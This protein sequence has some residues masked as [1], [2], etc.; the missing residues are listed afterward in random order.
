MASYAV[1]D[2]KRNQNRIGP[3]LADAAEIYFSDH[4]HQWNPTFEIAYWRE[5]LET[6]QRW[7][8]RLELPREKKWDEVINHLPP[9]AARDGFYVAGET[10]PD[11]FTVPGRN[12][13]H[14]CLLA[15]LGM[16]DGRLADP[17]IMRRTLHKVMDNWDWPNTWGWDYPLMA[18]TAARLGE[19]E[20]AIQALLMH[21]AKNTFLDN[22]HNPQLGPTLPVYLPANGGLLYAA[23]MMAAGWDGTPV[24]K[25][26][27]GFPEDGNWVVRWEGLKKAP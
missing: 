3:P 10:A 4:E 22:G 6:A 16:L 20:T 1:W 12:T 5:G 18:M 13:G 9:L 7:R 15:P 24:G 21:T 27:P 11:T 8:E 25:H 23:A 2:A 26:A 17:E 19:G 14:P